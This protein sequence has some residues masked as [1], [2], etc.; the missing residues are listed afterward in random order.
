MIKPATLALTVFGGFIFIVLLFSSAYTVSEV[1]Q[2]I[3]TEFGKP[4]G[5][6]INADPAKS[7][8]GL[9][10]KIPFIQTVNRFEKRVLEWDG[11]AMEMPTKDKLYVVVDNFARWRI[12]DPR[13]YLEQLNNERTAQSRLSTIIGNAAMNVV[14]SHDLIEVI[15]SDKTRKLAVDPDLVEV[16]PN[17]ASLA[18]IQRGRAVLDQ[19]I[20]KIASS[21]VKRIGIELLDVRF[22][23]INYNARVT[24]KIYDRMVSER[25]QIAER[26]RS[27]GA[28]EA[29]KITGRKEKDLREIESGAYRT[30]QELQGKADALATEI[31]AKAYSTSPVAADFYPFLKTLETYKTTLGRDSTVILTTDSDFFKYLKHIAPAANPSA[32]PAPAPVR[33]PAPTPAPA[34]GTPPA[35][36]PQL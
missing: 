13:A 27:E 6:P 29:A 22:K 5:R 26:F 9:H 31:Y 20:F 36:P 12:S 2:V 21:E 28:G 16:N 24:E 23:R 4:V 35:N 11:P 3:I 34:A 25:Q 33:A 18:A 10:F 32:K 14:A 17:A 19:E 1:E 30:V 15:R 7:E 8:A